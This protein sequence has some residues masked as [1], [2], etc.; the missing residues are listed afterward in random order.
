MN[1]IKKLL[2]NVFGDGFFGLERD[3]TTVK[4]NLHKS[5]PV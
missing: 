4:K 2:L 5:T 3:V 1:I